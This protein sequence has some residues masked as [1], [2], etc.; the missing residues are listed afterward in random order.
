VPPHAFYIIICSASLALFLAESCL[1]R[2]LN[3]RRSLK[4]TAA[5]SILK[6][7]TMVW[8]CRSLPSG[9]ISEAIFENKIPAKKGKAIDRL[10]F[11]H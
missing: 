4:F 7:C 2:H 3:C 5:R 1:D 8:K 10:S 6:P 9:M 11:L